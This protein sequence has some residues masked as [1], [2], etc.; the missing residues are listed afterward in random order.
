MDLRERQKLSLEKKC[1]QKL[2][3]MFGIGLGEA[4]GLPGR[5]GGNMYMSQGKGHLDHLVRP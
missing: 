1:L 3:A 2:F 5:S 4:S